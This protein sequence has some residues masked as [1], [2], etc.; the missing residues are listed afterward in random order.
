MSASSA[1]SSTHAHSSASASKGGAPC[2]DPLIDLKAIEELQKRIGATVPMPAQKWRPPMGSFCARTIVLKP[3]TYAQVAGGQGAAPGAF[4]LPPKNPAHPAAGAPPSS[5]VSLAKLKRFVEAPKKETSPKKDEKTAAPPMSLEKGLKRSP[6]GLFLPLPS[7][8]PSPPTPRSPPLKYPC[9]WENGAIVVTAPSRKFDPITVDGHVLPLQ[10]SRTQLT[11]AF[12]DYAFL[13]DV[14]TKI[15]FAPKIEREDLLFGSVHAIDKRER[16]QKIRCDLIDRLKNISIYISALASIPPFLPY[17][18]ARAYVAEQLGF[19]GLEQGLNPCGIYLEFLLTK[20]M[21]IDAEWSH[22]AALSLLSKNIY[23]VAGSP[24]LSPPIFNFCYHRVMVKKQ[25]KE[26]TLTFEVA[27]TLSVYSLYRRLSELFPQEN[28]L[29][30]F[31]DKGR[32]YVRF[33][34]PLQVWFP[35]AEKTLKLEYCAP[36]VRKATPA[37]SK[38]DT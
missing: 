30:F 5:G 35:R 22:R 24:S 10:Y 1:T 33:N 3:K 37:P 19:S 26:T 16:Q 32:P 15:P 20:D 29:L 21:L 12:E 4:V 9:D 17:I 38:T 11:T 13:I 6:A 36:P 23:V 27:K 8:S 34:W 28:C 2:K 7:P 18:K 25:K 14:L 31:A